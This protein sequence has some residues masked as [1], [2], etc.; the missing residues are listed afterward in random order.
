MTEKVTID[1]IVIYEE[2]I[3]Q[4]SCMDAYLLFKRKR[5]LE[6]KNY[7]A[8]V[9]PREKMTNRQYFTLEYVP[10]FFNLNPGDVI[11]HAR[12]VDLEEKHRQ[13]VK[14]WVELNNSKF[15]ITEPTCDCDTQGVKVHSFTLKQSEPTKPIEI[16]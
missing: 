8:V 14:N 3:K 2:P 13:K 4:R 15:I 11:S 10:G 12:L 9:Y 5:I 6:R 7:R 1:R 16:N